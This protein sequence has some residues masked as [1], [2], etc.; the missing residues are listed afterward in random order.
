MALPSRQTVVRAAT[1]S[2]R[3]RDAARVREAAASRTLLVFQPACSS[4]PG[5]GFGA[6]VVAV[7]QD[8]HQVT[9]E[10]PVHVLSPRQRVRGAALRGGTA[11]PDGAVLAAAQLALE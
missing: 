10:E 6:A 8:I 2:D 9:G 11:Q 3:D 5:D 1:A 7:L 4:Q